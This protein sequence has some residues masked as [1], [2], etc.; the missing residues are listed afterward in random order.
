MAVVGH[1][2]PRIEIVGGRLGAYW[3]FALQADR[4][5]HVGGAL[6]AP[7]AET[8][9]LPLLES[10]GGGF[11]LHNRARKVRAP[12]LRSVGGDFLAETVTEMR[13]PRLRVVGGDMDTRSAQGYYHPAVRVAGEWTICPGA[14]EDW[15]RRETARQALRGQAGPL[16]L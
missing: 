12:S 7:K 10:I 6:V 2:P 4:L 9:V 5:R 16:Y 14:V 13:V 1:I 3:V 11:L 15:T 8:A